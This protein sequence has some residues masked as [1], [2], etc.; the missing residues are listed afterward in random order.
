ME[1]NVGTNQTN[2]SISVI[3]FSSSPTHLPT[4]TPASLL[5]SPTPTGLFS[6]VPSAAITLANM[7]SP[8]LSSSQPTI[9]EYTLRPIQL[10][11]NTTQPIFPPI[12]SQP[13]VPPS[14]SA[15]P[16]PTSSPTLHTLTVKPTF[17]SPSSWPSREPTM[18]Q[19]S[20]YSA[21]PSLGYTRS[22]TK[23]DTVYVTITSPPT[24]SATTIFPTGVDIVFQHQQNKEPKAN[25]ESSKRIWISIGT[26]GG[27]GLLVATVLF[28]RKKVTL[29]STRRKIVVHTNTLISK[30]RQRLGLEEAW[31]EIR[32]DD[33]DEDN[34]NLCTSRDNN[35]AQP[36]V[37]VENKPSFTSSSILM[38]PFR[39]YRA[40][41]VYKQS[42]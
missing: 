40:A 30:T 29:T 39:N 15:T 4:A 26:I 32:F 5:P 6:N 8:L 13:T 37:P 27:I 2:T 35:S 23:Q 38:S 19:T 18:S 36:K 9:R 11:P 14:L 28:W 12:S 10:L 41:H 22:P 31:E 25:S 33:Y 16:A 3:A 7:S 17:I 1:P 21:V 20:E 34:C 42:E 24:S